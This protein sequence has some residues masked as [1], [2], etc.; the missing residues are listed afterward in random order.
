MPKTTTETVRQTQSRDKPGLE[1]FA[2][3]HLS[4]GLLQSVTDFVKKV[5]VENKRH[6][7]WL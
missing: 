1:D 4:G 6:A 2:A 7:V 3:T 5:I